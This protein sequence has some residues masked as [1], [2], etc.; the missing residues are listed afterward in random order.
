M[1]K[2]SQTLR[3]QYERVLGKPLQAF[4][5]CAFRFPDAARQ[6]LMNYATL[7][8]K[9]RGLL[10][11]SNENLRTVQAVFG[12]GEGKAKEFRNLAIYYGGTEISPIF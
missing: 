10:Y 12:K 6:R 5:V 4:E 9:L 8:L 2:T 3:E 1:K 11:D 7:S